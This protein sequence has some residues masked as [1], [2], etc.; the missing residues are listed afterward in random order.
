MLK[1]WGRKSSSNVQVVMWLIGE[2][3]LEYDRIDA[4]ISYGVVD[5]PEYRAINPMGRIPTLQD[6]DDKPLWE[7]VAILRYLANSYASAP[8]WPDD[9]AERAQVDM[10][11]E[12]AKIN[13]ATEFSVPI[14]WR[15]VRTAPS[16]RDPVAIAK[17]LKNLDFLLD[18]AEARLAQTTYLVGD[19]FTLADI[20]FS[21]SLFRYFD[22][23]IKRSNHPHLRRYYDL[24]AT[25][26]AFKEHVLVSYDELRVSD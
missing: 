5:T 16:K 19:E 17:A 10:W 3:G 9:P 25:R 14:F 1:I 13:F 23:D 6:G 8:L 2:L 11:T 24:I 4:G 12:W 7:S 15:V 18:I 26:P 22:I 21:V 20:Q